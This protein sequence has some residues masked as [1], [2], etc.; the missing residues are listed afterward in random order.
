MKMKSVLVA[1]LALFMGAMTSCNKSSD[2]LNKNEVVGNTYAAITLSFGEDSFR[3]SEE[4]DFNKRDDQWEGNDAIKTVD[5]YL[6]AG[7]IVSSGQYTLSDFNVVA[8]S[9][10]ETKLM[11]KK[12]IKTTAGQKTVYVLVNAPDAIRQT[13]AVT[14]KD[15]FDRAW[16]TVYT[17]HTTKADNEAYKVDAPTGMQKLAKLDADG[18]DIIMMSNEKLFT[19]DIEEGVTYE[20]AMA[21]PPKNRAV[22]P[23]KRVAARVV[24]TTKADSYNIVNPSTNKVIGQI[25]DIKYAVAQG[26]KK[27]Y[28]QQ[29]IEASIIKTPAY[30]VVTKDGYNKPE[31]WKKMDDW[32]DYSDLFIKTRKATQTDFATLDS[33]KIAEIEKTPAFMLEANHKRHINGNT[34]ATYDGDFFRGNTPYVLVRTK[35][36]PTQDGLAE[37]NNLSDI[38]N[39]TFYVGTTTGKIYTSANNVKDP[40][41]GGLVGQKFRKYENGKV[42]YYAYV[43]PDQ[44]DRRKVLD[45]PAFRNN[46]YHVHINDIKALGFNWNPLYP[47]NPD[48]PNPGA[49]G[50]PGDRT[51]VNPDPRPNE[52]GE[53]PV[54][55][56]KPEDPLGDKDIYM[57]VEVKVLKWNVHSYEVDLGL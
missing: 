46:V 6:V 55:P 27:M 19:M 7:D 40:A 25:T 51:P 28:I 48:D 54:P 5:V 20:A 10:Q 3:A 33:K 49:G 12:A 44:K 37:N 8:N 56:V 15:A 18:K 39:G 35:F 24:V 31:T 23:V 57:S 52:D 17:A 34:P 45:A 1:G 2:E 29:L 41:K 22:V 32:Y 38:Q 11:P 13:L 30:A 9:G 53:D 21:N 42:L 50:N 4:D 14:T 36:V 47:E 16:A 26:E 43:N